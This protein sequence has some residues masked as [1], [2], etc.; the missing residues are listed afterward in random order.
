ME[1]RRQINPRRRGICLYGRV[2]DCTYMIKHD[3]EEMFGKLIPLKMRTDSK[4]M[5]E[6]VTKSSSTSERRLMIDIEVAREAYNAN[7]ISNLGFVLSNGLSELNLA[8]FVKWSE[9]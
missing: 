3:L 9:C 5:F 6:V 2:S 7:E 1:A 8:R 4:Q